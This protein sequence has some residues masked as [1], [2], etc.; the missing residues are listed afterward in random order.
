MTELGYLA[1]KLPE[2]DVMTIDETLCVFFCCYVVGA[3]K[4]DRPEEMTVLANDICPVLCHL[5]VP[6]LIWGSQKSLFVCSVPDSKRRSYFLSFRV[7]STSYSASLI[8]NARHRSDTGFVFA[9]TKP[10]FPSPTSVIG[11]LNDGVFYPFVFH[12][13]P[14]SAWMRGRDYAKMTAQYVHF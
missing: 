2:F 10:D 7:R 3:N 13:Y 9:V 5:R 4:L 12:G 14:G 1:I 8:A 6:H 11:Q